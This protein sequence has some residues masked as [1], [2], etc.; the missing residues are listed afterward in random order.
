MSNKPFEWVLGDLTYFDKKIELIYFREKNLFCLI[1]HF[2]KY[3]KCYLLENKKIY[4]CI[5]E[6]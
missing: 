3:T 2:S 6:I 1:D 4:K 5:G